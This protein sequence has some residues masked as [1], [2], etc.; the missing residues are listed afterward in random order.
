MQHSV[1][2]FRAQRNFYISGF[3][4]FL[5]LVIRRLVILISDQ[6]S[7]LAQSQAS[8]GQ[9]QSATLAARTLMSRQQEQEREQSTANEESSAD[10]LADKEQ[11]EKLVSAMFELFIEDGGGAGY[12]R[13]LISKCVA[14][15]KDWRTRNETRPSE[16]VAGA[17][18][19]GQGSS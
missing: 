3:S 4:I 6:A 15:L 2:L 13:A 5:V 11:S 10:H 8:M 1:R 14:S 12:Y 17:R 16:W 9:A 19:E 7:L 18:A